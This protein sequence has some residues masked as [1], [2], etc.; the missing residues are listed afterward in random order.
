MIDFQKLFKS[1]STQDL[2]VNVSFRINSGEH[3]GIV[4]PNGIGK[5]TIFKMITGEEEP[6]K[7]NISIPH[8]YRISYLKQNINI[9]D[10]NIS[11]LD[12]T[13]DAIPELTKI[14]NC[15][16][17]LENSLKRCNS[18]E[19]KNKIL[20]E[21]GIYQTKFEHLGGYTI[22]NEAK[23]ALTG[24]GFKPDTLS[25]KLT[26]FSGGWQMR[27]SLAKVLIA[28]AEIMLLDE[29][30]NYLDIPA[31]EWLK[32]FLSSYQGTLLL[33]SHDR[34]LLNTL[35][36]VTFELNA[37]KITRYAGNYEY[38][39]RERISRGNQLEATKQN[40]DKRRKD[41]EKFVDRFK[42]KS[43][44][45]S[46]VQSRIKMLEKMEE[47]IIPESIN[48]TGNI[49]LPEPPKCGHE[50]IR[51]ENASFSY[52]KKNWILKNIDL[53]I[54]NG[55][56]IGVIGYNGTGK[57]TLLKLIADELKLISGKRVLGHHVVPGYQAQ[58]FSDILSPEKTVYDIVNSVTSDK[59]N[60]R[61]ILGSFGFSGENIDKPCKVLSG[62]EK[63]RL[64]FAR[65]FANP[66]NLIILDEPTTH[67][68][69]KTR[70]TL[71][72]TLKQ[73]KGTVCFVSHDI[74]FLKGTAS[75]IIYLSHTAELKKFYGN[76]NYYLEK[77]SQEKDIKKP[78]TVEKT[79]SGEDKKFIRQQ[80]AI[81]RQKF[82]KEKNMLEKEINNLEKKLEKYDTLKNEIIG[83][84]SLNDVMN[85]DFHSLTKKLNEINNSILGKT[86]KW[87]DYSMQLEEISDKEKKELNKLEEQL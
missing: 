77:T 48:Y 12:Y 43:S 32:K 59:S 74:E 29:P 49:K 14:Q 11:L 31:I 80:K 7:G 44:K 79:V 57:T 10:E 61:N 13:V 40:Q 68:D 70:E 38:Y 60:L 54:E 50:I 37:G 47:I 34:Y 24:L 6:D 28:N 16:S 23:S 30:S 4:G 53:R 82:S 42:Y 72:E 73:Y 75:T 71:Q 84:L 5:S 62:G 85:K 81:L 45:A 22:H 41:I 26:S 17:D 69:L 8:N 58:D 27:A 78:G 52:D 67:L 83:Q 18:D 39:S 86:E 3:V 55:E 51:L 21:I 1:Y 33:I 2:L 56:K 36:R 76:Y 25:N 66:P 46:Q 63:I 87:E 15:M 19:D 64:L 35:T 20:D 9:E 65:I